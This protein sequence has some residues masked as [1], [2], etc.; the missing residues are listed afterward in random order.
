MESIYDDPQPTA[1]LDVPAVEALPIRN[2]IQS[3]V[4][5]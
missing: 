5:G 1:G 3:A 2:R 4:I